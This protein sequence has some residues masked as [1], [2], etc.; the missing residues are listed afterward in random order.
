[1]HRSTPIV[2]AVI[3]AHVATAPLMA[4]EDCPFPALRFDWSHRFERVLRAAAA[5]DLDGDGVT[6]VAGLVE[7]TNPVELVRFRGRGDGAFYPPVPLATLETFRATI[8]AVGDF[9]GDGRDDLVLRVRLSGS[10]EGVQLLR[11]TP[12]GGHRLEPVIDLAHRWHAA[13]GLDVDL[14]GDRDLII[15]QGGDLLLLT[16]DRSGRLAAPVEFLDDVSAMATADLTGD[17]AADLVVARTGPI[18]GKRIVS[19][20]AAAPG[21]PAE[22][23]ELF[24]D[25][26][27]TILPGDLDADGDVEIVVIDHAPSA[28]RTWSRREGSGDFELTAS[29]ELTVGQVG[30]DAGLVD[31]TG[32]GR[33]EL[34]S[35]LARD[36]DDTAG[37]LVT[38][39][40][41]GTGDR[42][43]ELVVRSRGLP[44]LGSGGTDLDGDGD[45][46]LLVVPL[47]FGGIGIARNLGVGLDCDDDG[48]GDPCAVAADPAMDCDLSGTPDACDLADGRATDFDGDGLPD[49]CG[50]VLDCN[51]NGRIDLADIAD[52]SSVDCNGN[53][54]P[55]E[56][57][58]AVGLTAGGRR[59]D[60][61][62][63][64][65]VGAERMT[66]A[67]AC[68]GGDGVVVTAVALPFHGYPGVSA[69]HPF[70]VHVWSDPDGDGAPADAELL[71]SA[72][73]V[74]LA[75]N[76]GTT[77][78]DPLVQMVPIEPI[79]LDG[80]FFVGASWDGVVD[81]PVMTTVVDSQIP[82]GL[83]WA[84]FGGPE[85]LPAAVAFDA[86]SRLRQL[87]LTAVTADCNCNDRPDACDLDDGVIRDADGDGL[88]DAC[89][90][91]FDL[92]GDCAVTDADLEALLA[93]WG[94]CGAPP[95]CPAD[96]DGDGMVG[97]RDLMSI[98]A[99][100]G[101]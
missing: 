86:E 3:V 83:S 76:D 51:D 4:G 7:Y 49:D 21:G 57:E 30:S 27:Q 31:V 69:G 94:P 80:S 47:T 73:S 85:D 19:V 62:A 66:W 46:D 45:R 77:L 56:C 12:E 24:T 92:T 40:L 42:L 20:L 5:A 84:A 79:R 81:A 43:D 71:R 101:S 89:P 33:P 11:S 13:V 41:S 8:E 68:E 17:G 28:V 2:A 25:E 65:L 61:S 97:T 34:V 91:P 59:L 22:P 44:L 78:A 88:P 53:R 58:T 26:L 98:L 35:T 10:S 29:F 74:V 64:F 6:D 93:A 36:F 37:R 1:M 75:T 39:L 55:D 100:W 50:L 23:V 67:R 18:H 32:D 52:G 63:W 90:G 95:D 15:R 87:Y 54:I 96:L 82:T 38:T 14:D 9:D 99:A 16:N 72:S 70:E 60:T 48:L